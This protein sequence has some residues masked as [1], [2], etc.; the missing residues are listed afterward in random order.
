MAL[1]RPSTYSPEIAA[2]ICKRIA[3][4]ESLRGICRGKNMPPESTVRNWEI[5]N[6]DGF[7]AHV[8][9]AR[10]ARADFLAED[11]IEIADDSSGDDGNDSVQRS[12]LQVDARK[13]YASKV[14]PKKYGDF[15]KVDHEVKGT[16]SV[17]IVTGVPERNA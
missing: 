12:R 7:A 5:L 17:T 8:A 15:Q 9:R 6:T 3:E 14:A 16:M 4:G 11:I 2:E 13:W 1:G 10:E